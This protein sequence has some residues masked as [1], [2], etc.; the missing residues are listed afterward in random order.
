M[1]LAATGEKTPAEAMNSL[2]QQM[3]EMLGRL[4]RSGM[5]ACAPKLGKPEE[6]GAWLGRPGSPKAK[7]ANEKPQG[8]TV[9]YEEL[10]A[11]WKDGRVR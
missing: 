6:E 3:D 4:E 1:S 2:A 7:L 11:A 10:L 8:K 9:P 5:Q